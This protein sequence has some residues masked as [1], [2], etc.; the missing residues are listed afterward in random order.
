MRDRVTGDKIREVDGTGL[1][2]FIDLGRELGF[3]LNEI[4]RHQKPLNQSMT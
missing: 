3:V 1:K 4:Q 2:G